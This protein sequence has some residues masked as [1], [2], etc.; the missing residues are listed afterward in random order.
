MRIY[1]L[2]LESRKEITQYGSQ[3]VFFSRIANYPDPLHIGCLTIERNG[4]IGMHPA[5]VPQLFFV[6][7]GEGWVMGKEG[8]KT[9]L[10]AG[11]AAYW[12]AGEHHESGS[13]HGMTV[14][15]LE[16]RDLEP[17]MAEAD[18]QENYSHRNAW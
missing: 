14:L 9:V 15:V 13:E 1:Q 8:N 18:W 4:I 6:M 2:D 11:Q 10:R 17:L 12:E 16:S 3:N 5:P 7:N